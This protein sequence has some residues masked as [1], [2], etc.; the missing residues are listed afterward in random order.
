M[1]DE[2][3]H[4]RR[5]ADHREVAAKAL[6]LDEVAGALDSARDLVGNGLH[7]DVAAQTASAPRERLGRQHESRDAGLHVVDA[8]SVEPIVLDLRAE[9]FVGPARAYRLDVEVTVEDQRRVI[10]RAFGGVGQAIASGS[11]SWAQDRDVVFGRTR[12]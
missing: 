3:V 8:V 4:A 7:D 6:L 2:D 10:V 9:G 12:R 1:G 5:L 11:W